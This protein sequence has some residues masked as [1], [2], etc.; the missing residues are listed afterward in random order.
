[1]QLFH[2]F[3]FSFLFSHQRFRSSF[4]T[5]FV[6]EGA[7]WSFRARQVNILLSNQYDFVSFLYSLHSNQFNLLVWKILFFF[8]SFLRYSIL[9]TFRFYD[10]F[11]DDT[12]SLN[13][14]YYSYIGGVD[15]KKKSWLWR[16]SLLHQGS[17]EY[18]FEVFPLLL[19]ILTILR[20]NGRCFRN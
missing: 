14:R 6:F 20:Y 9:V 10:N 7:F 12:F 2:F 17:F 8:F 16:A 3:F 4:E 18:T 13:R 5:L 11:F 19:T 15:S 1:M